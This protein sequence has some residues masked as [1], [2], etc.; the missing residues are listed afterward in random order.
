[1]P[2]F[3]KD[4]FV[5]VSYGAH[6]SGPQ[7]GK[8]IEL[9]YQGNPRRY[10]VELNIG[11]PKSRHCVSEK[12]MQE[13]SYKEKVEVIM[14]ALRA[15][16]EFFLD[17]YLGRQKVQGLNP[18]GDWAYTGKDFGARSWAICSTHVD[19]WFEKIKT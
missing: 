5:S 13:I 8:V 3:H 12:F 16:Q 19:R 6:S 18:E 9:Y 10:L 11:D 4:Q 7:A 1:M 17:T 15:G 2:K 14:E